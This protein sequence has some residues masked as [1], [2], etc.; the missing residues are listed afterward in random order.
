MAIGMD[1]INATKARMNNQIKARCETLNGEHGR[2]RSGVH[3]RC[4]TA[5]VNYCSLRLGC[6]RRPV[7]KLVRQPG[8]VIDAVAIRPQYLGPESAGQAQASWSS[9]VL[10][11][12]QPWVGERPCIIRALRVTNIAVRNGASP[13]ARRAE[14]G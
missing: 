8:V 1:E 2:H 7:G 10:M 9:V 14:C 6:V 4:R 13:F 3:R 11:T 5:P 12:R